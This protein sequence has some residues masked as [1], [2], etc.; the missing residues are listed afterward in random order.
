MKALAHAADRYQAVADCLRGTDA[1]DAADLYQ[2]LA[3]DA[4]AASAALPDREAS[5]AMLANALKVACS[6]EDN[7]PVIRLLI[8]NL[9]DLT[10]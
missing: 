3:N 7:R 9:D 6:H 5:P 4:T 8:S 1:N 2:N 10:I